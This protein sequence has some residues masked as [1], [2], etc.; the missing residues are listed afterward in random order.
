MGSLWGVLLFREI[1]GKLNLAI[2]FLAIFINVVAGNIFET[3][4]PHS[5]ILLVVLIALSELSL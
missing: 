5:H 1:T 4:V 3:F 2:L